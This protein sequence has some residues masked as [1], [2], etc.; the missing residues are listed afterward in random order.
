[1]GTGM[2]NIKFE[3]ATKGGFYIALRR[4][5]VLINRRLPLRSRNK[6]MPQDILG[7]FKK[8]DK[9]DKDFAYGNKR[10]KS[11]TH[12][13]IISKERLLKFLTGEGMSRSFILDLYD[14]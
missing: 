14:N 6:R 8:L 10:T 9:V 12:K 2:I 3:R 5:S 4:S 11:V 1:M 13:A 7:W